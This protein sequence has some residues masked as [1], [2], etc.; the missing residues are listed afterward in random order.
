MLLFALARIGNALI[1]RPFAGGT[2]QFHFAPSRRAH[3]KFDDTQAK[4]VIVDPGRGGRFRKQARFGHS[5]NSV[6]F[7]NARLSVFRQ[8]HIDSRVDLQ[9]NRAIRTQGQILNLA[10]QFRFNFRRTNMFRAAAGLRIE[11]W[12]LVGEIVKAALGNDLENGQRLIAQNS[13][14]Q[15]AAGDKFF[16][17]KLSIEFARFGERR[18]QLTGLLNNIDSDG[19]S[20]PRRLDDQGNGQRR[21]FIRTNHLPPRSGDTAPLRIFFSIDFIECGPAFLHAVAGIRHAAIFQNLLELAV[22]AK[23]PVNGDEGEID[24]FRQLKIFVADIDFDNLRPERAQRLGDT[25][26]RSRARHRVPNP[27]R[28]LIPRFFLVSVVHVLSPFLPHDL[29]FGFQFD[30]TFFPSRRLNFLDQLQHFRRG[31]AAVIHNKIAMHLRDPR[32]SDARNFS[33]PSSSTNFP[34]GHIVRIFENAARALRRR[35]GRRRFSC[36][37]SSLRTISS[38]PARAAPRNTAETA[39]FFSS[40]GTFR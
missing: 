5:R 7:Q 4:L 35:L 38:F 40:V 29:H 39:K 9:A 21:L 26:D 14:R 28:P 10:R 13:D 33:S 6:Y 1:A 37:S 11:K 31:R 20:L 25:R 15:F 19:R 16:H 23:R 2:A 22:F 8:E 34:A 32:F 12:I 3:D 17:Q 24:I 30:P 18:L 27:V 36:D